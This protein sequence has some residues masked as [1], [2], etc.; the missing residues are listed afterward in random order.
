MSSNDPHE[1]V[2]VTDKRRVDPETGEVREGVSG[3]APRG[4]VP[5]E[6]PGETPEEADKASELLA[7]LQRVQADFANYR[8]RALRDQQ[9]TAERAK[10][11][12]VS[13]MLGVL[14]D[15]D[16][17]RS[18]GELES[19]PLESVAD[20][21]VTALDGL[22]LSG[23]GAEGDEFDP[24][25]HEAVQHEI[26][27][28]RFRTSLST[29]GDVDG[30]SEA[31]SR[32]ESRQPVSVT[33][34]IKRSHLTAAG[35][36]ASFD[37]KQGIGGINNQADACRSREDVLPGLLA[38]YLC[39]ERAPGR[40]PDLLDIKG[41]QRASEHLKLIGFD[42]SKGRCDPNRKP[43]CAK[44]DQADTLDQWRIGIARIPA[45]RIKSRLDRR[46]NRR[47]ALIGKVAHTL[48]L[49]TRRHSDEG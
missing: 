20:K 14:D 17:A 46:S 35:A 15:L 42:A 18:H 10:A 6:F 33:T 34:R 22:V 32:Q 29:A 44:L 4:P 48:P 47:K 40:K 39:V 49:F 37:L 28:P 12:V 43:A 38:G 16:R 9:L 19:G 3:P 1:P 27:R 25:L 2:T 30:P 31:K 41:C 26:A 45:E 21:L 7:D 24:A 36:R 23:F 11:A 13:Q 5:G 8:K